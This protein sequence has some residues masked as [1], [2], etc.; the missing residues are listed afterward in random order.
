MLE[1]GY[2]NDGTQLSYAAG[3]EIGKYR[4]AQLQEFT[5][6]AIRY[7]PLSILRENVVA[8]LHHRVACEPALRVVFLRRIVRY[9]GRLER[10]GRRVIVERAP[11]PSAAVRE[12]LAVLHHEINVMLGTWH[13]RLTGVRLLFFRI[14]MD[15]RH[16]GVVRERLAIAGHALL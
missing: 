8:V 4:A 15:F 14:P 5:A 3:L 11:S 1:R 16:L 6:L 10:I 7:S 12:P 13:R 2:L 9:G